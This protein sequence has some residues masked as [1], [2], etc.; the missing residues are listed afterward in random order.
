MVN[1]SKG[2]YKGP[3][4]KEDIDLFYGILWYDLFY[5]SAF[6]TW[7]LTG[8][9]VTNKPLKLITEVGIISFFATTK[10]ILH[11]DAIS[12]ALTINFANE[13]CDKHGANLWI[14]ETS[15]TFKNTWIQH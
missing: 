5:P 6:L 10:R 7:Q 1:E 11:L 13:N 4:V 12:K 15:I 14:P 3:N 8:T 9:K 2:Q